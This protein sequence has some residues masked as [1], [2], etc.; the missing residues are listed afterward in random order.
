VIRF[1]ARHGIPFIPNIWSV[2]FNIHGSRAVEEY[3]YRLRRMPFLRRQQFQD[4]YEPIR[5]NLVWHAL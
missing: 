2:S 4:F 1:A 3:P 5:V